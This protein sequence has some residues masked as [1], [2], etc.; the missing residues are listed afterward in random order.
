V[1]QIL[2]IELKQVEGKRQ[3]QLLFVQL[4]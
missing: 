1:P 3:G 4:D 2:A